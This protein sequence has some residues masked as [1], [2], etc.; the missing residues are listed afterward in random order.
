MEFSCPACSQAMQCADHYGGRTTDC[1]KCGTTLLIPARTQAT[2]PPPPIA[3]PGRNPFGAL[4]GGPEPSAKYRGRIDSG[5]NPFIGFVIF[6]KM[7]TPWLLIVFYW[8][9]VV[10][11]LGYGTVTIVNSL[12]TSTEAGEV[13]M[14]KRTRRA[15]ACR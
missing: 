2:A 9:S 8:L 3:P 7:I 13:G 5:R 1:P 6:E 4:E 14:K 12:A 10:F 11:F 15:A